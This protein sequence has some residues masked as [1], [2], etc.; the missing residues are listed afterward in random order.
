MFCVFTGMSA[1]LPA[2]S[3]ALPT[4]CHNGPDRSDRPHGSDRPAGLSRLPWP[5]RP[6]GP[7]R[8][9]GCHRC[10]PGPPGPQGPQGVAG[11]AGAAGATG[12][13]GPQGR[14]VQRAQLVWQAPPALRDPPGQ[15]AADR[16]YRRHGSYC[17]VNICTT[18]E[19]AVTM[20]LSAILKTIKQPL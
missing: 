8:C 13:T 14:R 15:V 11:P 4:G 12:A 20:R 5:D 3:A 17:S 1:A 18:K 9:G 10:P 7:H 16:P 2:G 19:N 6:H